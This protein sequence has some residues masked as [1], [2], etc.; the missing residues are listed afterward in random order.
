MRKFSIILIPIFLLSSVVQAN[1]NEMP[2]LVTE[3][4]EQLEDPIYLV[5]Q[6][7]KK[8]K[9]SSKKR[10]KSRSAITLNLP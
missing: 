1:S 4:Q 2:N 7:K 10:R 5:A 9:K 3:I 8:K 6:K